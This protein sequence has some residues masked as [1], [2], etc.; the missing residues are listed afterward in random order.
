MFHWNQIAQKVGSYDAAAVVNMIEPAPVS[1]FHI[2]LTL[3]CTTD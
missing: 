1:F 3:S 2:F